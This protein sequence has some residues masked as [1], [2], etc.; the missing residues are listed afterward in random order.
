MFIKIFGVFKVGY[1][2]GWQKNKSR[3]IKSKTLK[4]NK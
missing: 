2:N 1:Q 4:E 3:Q